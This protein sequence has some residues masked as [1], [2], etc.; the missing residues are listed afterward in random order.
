MQVVTA[1]HHAYPRPPN[2]AALSA[3]VVEKIPTYYL[4]SLRGHHR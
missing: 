4:S 2:N 1:E 3:Y